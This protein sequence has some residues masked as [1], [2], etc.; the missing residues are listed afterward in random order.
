[1]PA[2][3]GI[4]RQAASGTPR[5]GRPVTTTSSGVF[6]LGQARR[7]AKLAER[8]T[9]CH[10]F[11]FEGEAAPTLMG[12]EFVDRWAGRT[13]GD[14]LERVN[15]TQPSQIADGTLGDLQALSRQQIADVLAFILISN[16]YP[17]GQREL[18]ID[19]TDLESIRFAPPPA[20]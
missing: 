20:R 12:P 19:N 1:M 5:R 8:C 3:G 4:Q 18:S 14:M 16:G 7:G 15:A 2:A 11:D 10:G 13:L 9:L 17:A 6:T